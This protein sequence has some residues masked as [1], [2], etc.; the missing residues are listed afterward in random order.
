M[1]NDDEDNVS[2]GSVFWIVALLLFV[3]VFASGY[4]YEVGRR[5]GACTELC[6]PSKFDSDQSVNGG[7]L[8]IGSDKVLR[9]KPWKWR[10]TAG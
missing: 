3:G 5:S 6:R 2:L 8:C 1:S 9:I 10:L 4:F 7:C